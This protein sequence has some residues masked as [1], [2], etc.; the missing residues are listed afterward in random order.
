MATFLEQKILKDLPLGLPEEA[1]KEILARA[2][3]L[4]RGGGSETPKDEAS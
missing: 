1:T 2:E 3:V 4:F